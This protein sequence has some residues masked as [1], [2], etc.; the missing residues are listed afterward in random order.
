MKLKH[1][2]YH[3]SRPR[4]STGEEDATNIDTAGKTAHEHKTEAINAK[5][6][7]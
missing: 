4:P 3:V 6:K 7:T 5:I 1:K 2:T